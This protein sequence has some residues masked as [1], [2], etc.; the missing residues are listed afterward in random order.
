MSFF[1]KKGVS[2]LEIIVA[3]SILAIALIPISGIMSKQTIETDRN[4]STAFAINKASE[5]LT[6]LLTAVPFAAIRQGNPGYIKV[7]DICSIAKYSH[8]TDAWAEKVV[9]K[10]FQNS[11]KTPNGWLCQATE[12]D[13]R[14]IHYLVHLKV[15]DV[16]AKRK[17]PRPEALNIGDAFPNAAPNEF[18][19]SDELSFAY[20]KNPSALTDPDWFVDYAKDLSETSKPLT[21]LDLMSGR[22]VAISPNNLYLDESDLSASKPALFTNPTAI[23][24]EPKMFAHPVSHKT[25][26][27]SLY[28]PLKKLLIQVQWNIEPK[29]FDKPQAEQGRV[30]RIHLIT[31]KGNID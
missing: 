12:V 7:D 29:Y 1:A 30:Q 17:S 9:A 13:N 14:G 16:P 21:E 18:L 10:L 15:E 4:V 27:D 31:I 19:P 26:P 5:V 23:K 22:G 3:L 28:S 20:L 24:Y 11:V 6:T 8:Y 2:F 25:H